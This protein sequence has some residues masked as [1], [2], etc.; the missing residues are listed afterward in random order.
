MLFVSIQLRSRHLDYSNPAMNTHHQWWLWAAISGM[1]QAVQGHVSSLV[2]DV[3]LPC[4]KLML[5]V[6]TLRSLI[7]RSGTPCQGVSPGKP[8]RFS[9]GQLLAHCLPAS[10]LVYMALTCLPGCPCKANAEQ[11]LRRVLTYAMLSVLPSHYA[12]LVIVPNM[13][14]SIAKCSWS[15]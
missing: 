12:V 5:H 13:V 15:C 8:Q 2:A 10:Y 7:Q 9:Q 14:S 3:L 1:D 11:Y 6:Q 4:M